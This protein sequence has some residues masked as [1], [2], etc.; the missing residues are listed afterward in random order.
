V[1]DYQGLKEALEW[2]E[3][4]HKAGHAQ[5]WTSAA[6]CSNPDCPHRGRNLLLPSG[7]LLLPHTCRRPCKSDETDC[8]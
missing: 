5:S 6:L 1:T 3:S 8:Q 2:D 4:L 7:L